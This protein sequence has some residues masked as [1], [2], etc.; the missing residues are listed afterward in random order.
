VTNNEPV[1]LTA[2]LARLALESKEDVLLEEADTGD[3]FNSVMRLENLCGENIV[4]AVESIRDGRTVVVP[5][6]LLRKWQAR[7][8]DAGMYDPALEIGG[9]I[10]ALAGGA[11]GE[12]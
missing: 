12:A 7:F 9:H 2:E 1:A 6:E 8:T 11:G 3:V 10:G 5:V 4:R